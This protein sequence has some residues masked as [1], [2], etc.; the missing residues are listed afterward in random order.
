M[1]GIFYFYIPLKKH[2]LISFLLL[3]CICGPVRATVDPLFQHRMDSLKKLLPGMQEDTVLIYVLN[4]LG[5]ELVVPMPEEAIEYARKA[6]A[7]ST[8]MEHIRGIARAENIIGCYYDDKNNYAE[9][10]THYFKSLDACEKSGWKFM[11]ANT[12]NYIGIVY[13]VR[14]NHKDARKFLERARD[15]A[16]ERKDKSRLASILNNLGVVYKD[17]GELDKAME[18]YKR[19]LQ[20]FE[21]LG[22]KKGI[23]SVYI[24]MGVVHDKKGENEI[25]IDYNFKALEVFHEIND[26]LGLGIAYMNVADS[27]WKH[28]EPALSIKYMQL[29]EKYLIAAG[30]RNYIQEAYK[31]FARGYQGI[32]DYRQAYDYQVR[33]DSLKDIIFGEESNRQ[34]NE[35]ET[36]YATSEKEK[37]IELQKEQLEKN[38][39]VT[40]AAIIGSVLIL[41]LLLVIFN[42]YKL[43][44]R[45]NSLLEAQNKIIAEKQKDITDSINYAKRIQDAILPAKEIKY[46]L[47][48]DAFVMLK[49]RDNVSGDFYWFGEQEGKRIIAAVDCTGH[50]VP[51]AFMSL[52]G[53]TFLNEIV[54]ECNITVPSEILSELRNR[55]IKSLKQTSSLDAT[56]DGM[57]IALLCFDD[58]NQ[59]VEY[60]GANN[61]LWIIRNGEIIEFQ[62]D[63]RPIGYFQ[64]KGLPFTNNKTTYQKGDALYVFTDGYADQFGGPEGKKFMRKRLK[65]LLLMIQDKN[66]E[67]QERFLEK[68]FNDWKGEKEQVD[69]V[70]VIGIRA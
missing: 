50:G 42:R 51:G 32:G 24:N 61:P 39:I 66:M 40:Y 12:L 60:A 63:K 35:L 25:A 17:L 13:L 33:Y 56:R 45:A 64:G 21:E 22:H 28:K 19:Q 54:H 69:D 16:E 30:D 18:C 31:T 9:A 5:R 20:V 8:E 38:R 29:G 58:A 27:Y 6:L 11:E 62:A 49:P 59:V 14:E 26:N 44:Q 52:I 1:G 47:F 67:Q 57:D 70:L 46:Q 37:Q 55:I 43:K 48:P 65:E 4:E 41:G 23:G 7:L 15:I 68:T 2:L 34:I 53:N 10:L 36:K 3:L